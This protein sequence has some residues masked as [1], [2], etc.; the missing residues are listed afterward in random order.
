[1]NR[2]TAPRAPRI[3]GLAWGHGGVEGS[4]PARRYR[5]WSVGGLS[6]GTR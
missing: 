3:A 5:I 4:D 1:M 6:H 2:T